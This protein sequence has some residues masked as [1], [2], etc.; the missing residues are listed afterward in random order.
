MDTDKT[1][2][3]D[4]EPTK[5]D[6][7]PPPTETAE[8]AASTISPPLMPCPSPS[9]SRIA[10]SNAPGLRCMYIWVVVRSL[11]PASSWIAFAEAPRIARCEQ[12]VCL[13]R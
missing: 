2:S 12:N 8:P 6:N 13:S 9:R 7:G 1:P 3:E 4:L 10:S 5:A 11:W